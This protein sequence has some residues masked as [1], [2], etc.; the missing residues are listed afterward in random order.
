MAL[1]QDMTG[2]SL[3]DKALWKE[4]WSM[5][6][7]LMKCPHPDKV[8]PVLARHPNSKAAVTKT[9]SHLQWARAALN[10]GSA[11]AIRAVVEAL[12]IPK[13]APGTKLS[14][15]ERLVDKPRNEALIDYLLE[16]GWPVDIDIEKG[17]PSLVLHAA[18]MNDV[19][20]VEK[21]V[22]HGANP[23]RDSQTTISLTQWLDKQE[24]PDEMRKA[25]AKGHATWLS[26]QAVGR[27]DNEITAREPRKM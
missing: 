10:S 3:G 12:G 20:L 16:T 19:E 2:I 4:G 8:L 18:Q 17:G 15:W 26:K 5:P 13:V 27:P 14:G 25:I 22:A 21:L 9:I 1:D 7:L 11:E 6:H 24:K 23:Q